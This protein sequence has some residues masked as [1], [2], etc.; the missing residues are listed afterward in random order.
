M[1]HF[2]ILGYADDDYTR[3]AVTSINHTIFRR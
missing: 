1:H 2:V 3:S